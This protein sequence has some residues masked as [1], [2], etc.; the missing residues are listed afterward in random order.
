[1]H[2][3]RAE[4]QKWSLLSRRAHPLHRAA[5]LAVLPLRTAQSEDTWHLTGIEDG[6]LPTTSTLQRESTTSSIHLWNYGIGR[7]RALSG[8]N[9]SVSISRLTDID[10]PF[11]PNNQLQARQTSEQIASPASLPGSTSRK[12]CAETK[13]CFQSPK[14][15]CVEEVAQLLSE[16]PA[17]SVE[18]L[19]HL[20]QTLDTEGHTEELLSPNSNPIDLASALDGLPSRQK[21]PVRNTSQTG[22]QDQASVSADVKF[23]T[24]YAT[25]AWD[26]SWICTGQDLAQFREKLS[27]PL[28]P[29]YNH[30]LNEVGNNLRNVVGNKEMLTTSRGAGAS[31]EKPSHSTAHINVLLVHLM[32]H[33]NA[34]QFDGAKPA[35]PT[36]TLEPPITSVKNK[37]SPLESRV[38]PSSGRSDTIGYIQRLDERGSLRL[39]PVSYADEPKALPFDYFLTPGVVQQIV[40]PRDPS[41]YLE[42]LYDSVK[43]FKRE[44]RGSDVHLTTETEQQR[45]DAEDGPMDDFR[46]IRGRSVHNLATEYWKDLIP[47]VESWL[48]SKNSPDDFARF[49][50]GYFTLVCGWRRYLCEPK[51]CKDAVVAWCDEHQGLSQALKLAAARRPSSTAK[52]LLITLPD[53]YVR[54]CPYFLMYAVHHPGPE[55]LSIPGTSKR[56]YTAESGGRLQLLHELTTAAYLWQ[57]VLY[58]RGQAA[59]PKW[60][61]Q[62]L[63]TK[64]FIYRRQR[65]MHLAQGGLDRPILLKRPSIRFHGKSVLKILFEV[66]EQPLGLGRFHPDLL[67]LVQALES[68]NGSTPPSSTSSHYEAIATFDNYTATSPNNGQTSGDIRKLS[69]KEDN[70]LESFWRLRRLFHPDTCRTLRYQLDKLVME[71]ESKMKS[72]LLP[73]DPFL[74]FACDY[75]RAMRIWDTLSNARQVIN[76]SLEAV[77]GVFRHLGDK[78]K[79][80]DAVKRVAEMESKSAGL[81]MLP[82]IYKTHPASSLLP[83]VSWFDTNK[84]EDIERLLS[85]AAIIQ[86][87]LDNAGERGSY[88]AIMLRI[89]TIIAEIWSLRDET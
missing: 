24:A 10:V 18:I 70:L 5:A 57:L 37:L 50:L 81:R 83:Y 55:M 43:R 75:I 45:G 1:M 35:K 82:E 71:T 14:E 22:T 38:E 46:V 84:P 27:E 2:G 33:S 21:G 53:I 12:R 66:F 39:H 11:P 31:L 61:G 9:N 25:K 48:R 34:Q 36:L 44:F 54:T 80:T 20:I 16:D 23:N 8:A 63:I 73:K 88:K 72:G 85:A 3:L 60:P 62:P 59:K 76:T 26:S 64:K 40:L 68:S 65:E 87:K 77:R 19:E 32:Q 29:H 47:S 41:Q 42:A 51:W 74:S 28:P 56:R 7:Q 89:L 67:V 17:Q 58:I 78:Y 15:P 4:R 6:N 49:V 30:S 13:L 86:L 69:I 79:I 52:T